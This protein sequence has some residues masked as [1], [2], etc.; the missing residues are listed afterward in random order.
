MYARVN[1]VEGRP[2]R[3]DDAIAWW[4]EHIAPAHSP[5]R[6]GAIMLVDRQTGA[7]VGIG[8]WES[9]EAMERSE[10]GNKE[11]LREAQRD[12]GTQNAV[13]EHYEIV[14]HLGADKGTGMARVARFDGSRDDRDAGTAWWN[15]NVGGWWQSQPGC[16][17]AL[18]LADRESGKRISMTLWE[19][20]EALRASQSAANQLTST[21]TQALD[22]RLLGVEVYEVVGWV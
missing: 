8:L 18:L 14:S 22:L 9:R 16:Q 19:S 2:E 15:Q 20:A 4:R 13:V 6:A 10:A 17:G 5:G 11:T 1:R 7:G 3:V 12:V 21:G